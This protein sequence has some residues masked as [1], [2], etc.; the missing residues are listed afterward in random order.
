MKLQTLEDLFL[1]ELKDL[2]SAENQLVKA[3]PEMAQAATNPE[4]KAGF[5]EHLEQTKGHVERLT[6]IGEQLGKKLTGHTMQSHGR[7][8]RRGRG[9]DR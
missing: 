2:Y 5:E 8:G 3:L 4:L 9:A 1:H 6:K 7:L